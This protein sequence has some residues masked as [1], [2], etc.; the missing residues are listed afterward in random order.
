MAAIDWS[1]VIAFLALL[2]SG[3]TFWRTQRLAEKQ[4]E[5]IDDQ[6]RLNRLLLEREED[7]AVN[8]KRADLSANF[9]RTGKGAVVKVFNSGPAVATN[10]R[11]EVP[12]STNLFIQSDIDSKFPLE[13][14]EPHRGVDLIA[15]TYLGAAS[16]QY[17]TIIW[18]DAH[19]TDNK[20]VVP[21]TL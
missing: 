4:A 17:V 1:A 12:D 21:L 8:A 5:L 14:L 19:A 7:A 13:R 3:F 16:K 2:F 20:K 18:D 11:L 10:I 9:V 15:T 6:K